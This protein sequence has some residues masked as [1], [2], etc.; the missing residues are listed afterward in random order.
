MAQ[1]DLETID[2]VVTELMMGRLQV[3]DNSW[4][5]PVNN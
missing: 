2:L 1:R 3:S 4:F 5:I